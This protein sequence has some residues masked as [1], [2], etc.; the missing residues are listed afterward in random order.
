MKPHRLLNFQFNIKLQDYIDDIHFGS[1]KQFVQN[2]N[3]GNWEKPHTLRECLS[4]HMV[5]NNNLLDK[6]ILNDV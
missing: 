6:E 4:N 3:L 1:Y 5:E 2:N